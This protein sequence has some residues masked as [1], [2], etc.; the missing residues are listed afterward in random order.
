[1]DHQG[2]SLKAQMKAADRLG[3]RFVLILGADELA[4]GEATLRDMNTKVE[5][6]VALWNA[7]DEV[8][9]AF[10]DGPNA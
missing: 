2:K 5:R 8:A 7:A 10:A 9:H 3:A 6:R 1:M 4:V